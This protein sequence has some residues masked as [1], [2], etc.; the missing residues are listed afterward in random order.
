VKHFSVAPFWRRHL[1]RAR[2]TCVPML[3]EGA[4]V[5]I[6][7]LTRDEVSPFTVVSTASPLGR[8]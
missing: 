4:T 8:K 1:Q 3:R 2:S 7:V 5:G 6:L